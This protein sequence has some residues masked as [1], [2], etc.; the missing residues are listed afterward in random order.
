ME[1]QNSV[2]EQRRFN[3]SDGVRP[4]RRRRPAGKY[5]WEVYPDYW[6]ESWGK[7]PLLGRVVA[8]DEF[9]AEREAYNRGLLIVNYTFRP[10]VIKVGLAD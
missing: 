9:Y 10:R 3:N 5:L 4:V 2:K 7:I 8:D 6:K 1:K